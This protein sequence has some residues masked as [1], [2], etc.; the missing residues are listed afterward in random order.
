MCG[1][2][3]CSAS[4]TTPCQPEDGVSLSIKLPTT[5]TDLLAMP[6]AEPM[7]YGM[8][9]HGWITVL[10]MR[11]DHTPLDALELWIDESYRAVAPK[12][13]LAEL[14][15]LRASRSIEDMPKA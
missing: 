7:G 3:P 12:R 6:F 5:G 13:R 15:A 11:E 14:D 4:A 9:K 10:L 1:G 8:G 2:I